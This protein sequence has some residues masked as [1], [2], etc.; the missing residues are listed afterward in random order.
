MITGWMPKIVAGFAFLLLLLA[1][2]LSAQ[3][4][5][6][7]LSC[8]TTVDH[9]ISANDCLDSDTTR[10]DLYRLQG[11]AG[12]YVD[13]A[14]APLDGSLT[15]PY[16][17]LITPSGDISEAPFIGGGGTPRLRFILTASGEWTIAVGTMRA[18][19]LGRYRLALQCQSSAIPSDQWHCV[20]QQFS[21]GQIARWRLDPSSCQFI[22]GGVFAEYV[23]DFTPGAPMQFRLHSDD[24]DPRLGIYYIAG[25]PLVRGIGVRHLTDAQLAYTVTAPAEPGTYHLAASALNDQ[26]S[27][28]FTLY[29]DCAAPPVCVPPLITVP[30]RSATVVPG[31][32]VTLE[33]TVSGSGPFTYAWHHS[34]DPAAIG[35]SPRLSVSKLAHTTSYSVDVSNACGYTTSA[36][37]V[38][39]VKP[40]R[41]RGA[42]H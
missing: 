13:L 31:T 29:G 10:Y 30:P 6:T 35:S 2:P 32:S 41:E 24:F 40:A 4:L 25:H 8:N 42:R 36:A 12:D 18:S 14:V 37:A 39:T 28:A 19:D 20:K 21:C 11:A 1:A 7:V 9:E 3:C 33:V 23:I 17:R 34:D 5:A 38:I 26:T 16:L 22:D 15:M 27:G